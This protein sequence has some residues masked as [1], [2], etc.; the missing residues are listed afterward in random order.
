MTLESVDH[1]KGLSLN[2][3]PANASSV[4]ADLSFRTKASVVKQN[5]AQKSVTF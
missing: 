2:F 5:V 4:Q 1:D 3:E